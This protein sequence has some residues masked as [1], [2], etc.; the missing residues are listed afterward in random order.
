MNIKSLHKKGNT[1]EV[2]MNDGS[3]PTIIIF[4]FDDIRAIVRHYF[5]YFIK[6][7]I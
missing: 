3:D 5:R 2:T 4:T 7:G 1:L 6:L